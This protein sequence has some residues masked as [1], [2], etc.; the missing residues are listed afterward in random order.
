MAK[1]A[2]T[3]PALEFVRWHP[4]IVEITRD[5]PPMKLEPLFEA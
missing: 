1:N 3:I 5:F 4:G 2:E